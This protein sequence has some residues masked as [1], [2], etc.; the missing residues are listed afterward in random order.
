MNLALP[1][2]QSVVAMATPTYRALKPHV[3]FFFDAI[4]DGNVIAHV[5]IPRATFVDAQVPDY[6]ISLTMIIN[7]NEYCKR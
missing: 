2:R 4:T 3:L 5:A 6:F 7:G 1:T